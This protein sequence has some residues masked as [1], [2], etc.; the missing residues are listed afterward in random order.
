MKKESNVSKKGL[1]TIR[2]D[3]NL[4]LTLK[5]LRFETKK[6]NSEIITECL[7]GK[8]NVKS[9]ECMFNADD[10]M[11]YIEAL[12]LSV[13]DCFSKCNCYKSAHSELDSW[14]C[15]VHGYKKG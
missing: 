7:A 14:V 1:C 11:T 12:K 5:R 3:K 15:P 13:Q 6:T 9:T 8:L 4:R 10:I 2:I